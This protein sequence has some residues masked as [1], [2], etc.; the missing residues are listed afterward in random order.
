MAW[1]GNGIGAAGAWHGMCELAFKE[2]DNLNVWIKVKI[3]AYDGITQD[4]FPG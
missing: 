2:Q 4:T 3:L 1:Q